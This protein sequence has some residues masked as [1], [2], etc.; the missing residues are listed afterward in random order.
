MSGE[1]KKRQLSYDIDIA[2]QYKSFKANVKFLMANPDFIERLDSDLKLLLKIDEST[3]SLNPDEM[4][5]IAGVTHQTV[6]N[7]TEDYHEENLSKEV[8]AKAVLRIA[9]AF[10]V[11]TD[12]L[13]GLGGNPY[14]EIEVEYGPFE[15]VGFSAEAYRNLLAVSNWQKGNPHYLDGLNS[16]L[17]YTL[18]DDVDYGDSLSPYEASRLPILEELSKYFSTNPAN[19]YVRLSDKAIQRIIKSLEA[20][21]ETYAK[22][23]GDCWENAKMIFTDTLH[24]EMET[25]DGMTIENTHLEAIKTALYKCR[26]K[27]ISDYLTMKDVTLSESEKAMLEYLDY[28]YNR[29]KHM[30]CPSSF[31][32]KQMLEKEINREENSQ[33]EN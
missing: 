28:Y 3:K 31:G 29:D 4:A 8:S 30:S 18:K 23:N 7:W 5:I 14:R 26:G 10:K 19:S 25:E 27:Y 13:Y 33:E 12:W 16:I 9:K 20:Y 15:A 17:E 24:S 11:S 1:N 21:D 32:I 22:Y 6:R 2:K